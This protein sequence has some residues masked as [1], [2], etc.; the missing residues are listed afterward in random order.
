[1]KKFQ[2]IA[3]GV[4]EGFF[5]VIST[6]LVM[7]PISPSNF[8]YSYRDS[9]VFLYTGWRIL[10]GEIP[11]IHIWDHKPPVIFYLNAIG[12]GLGNNSVWGVWILEVI[13]LLLASYLGYQLLKKLF[14]VYAAVIGTIVWM[15]ALVFVLQGGN[16]TTEYALLFQF[17]ALYLFYL[18]RKAR[19]PHILMMVIGVLGGLAFFTKQTVIGIWIAMAVYLLASGLV[20]RKLRANLKQILSIAVGFST[21]TLIIIGYF[22]YHSALHEF[23]QAAFVYNFA[24]SLRKVSGLNA[25]ILGLLDVTSITRTGI[26]HYSTLGI[27]LFI[28]LY[29]KLERSI[30]PIMIVAL[31]AFP[32]DLLLVNSPGTTYPHYY[33]TLLPTLSLF[34]GLLFKV[35]N[36]VIPKWS[37]E[38]LQK[39]LLL[40]LTVVAILFGSITDYRAN[41]RSLQ[42][43]MNEPAILYV[44]DR[45]EDDDYVLVW[46]AESMVNFYTRRVSPTRFVYQYPLYREIFVTEELVIEFLDGIIENPPKFILNSYGKHAPLYRFSIQSEAI[47]E[48]INLIRSR[49]ES[50]DEVNRWQ[51]LELIP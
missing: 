3:S 14:G 28:F 20:Q 23:W 1:M 41:N 10:N 32:L 19:K 36:D 51:V 8:A 5:I 27:I 16:L 2:N 30:Q 29:K 12:L 42:V 26:Y 37:N 15:L 4:A 6:L 43:R 50:V 9:G 48:R 33:M 39:G 31:I 13:F 44:M 34:S 11:Y 38:F 40:S 24:Y 25:R 22:L 18:S 46:G 35:V 47:N 7:M 17:G 49:Y 21:V 45:T